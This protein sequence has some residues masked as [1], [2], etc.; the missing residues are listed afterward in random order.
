MSDAGPS[1]SK[2]VNASF[3]SFYKRAKQTTERESGGVSMLMMMMIIIH[4]NNNTSSNDYN[5]PVCAD[6]L[7]SRT[8]KWRDTVAARAN[9]SLTQTTPS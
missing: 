3:T 7:A 6:S 1:S 9:A 5:T 2:R 8:A 4:N